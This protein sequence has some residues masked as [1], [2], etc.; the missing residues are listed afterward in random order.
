MTECDECG[1][2]HTSR[3]AAEEC[4]EQDRIDDMRQR[5]TIRSA[6]DRITKAKTLKGVAGIDKT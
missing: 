1:L 5:Q 3:L 6:Q 2:L 4:A